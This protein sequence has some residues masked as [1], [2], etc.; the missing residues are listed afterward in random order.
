M[1]LRI[2]LYLTFVVFLIFSCS[3]DEVS[4]SPKHIYQADDIDVDN[5]YFPSDTSDVWEHI[6][7][8]DYSIDTVK[9]DEL[10]KWVKSKNSTAFLMSIKGRILTEN[11]WNGVSDSRVLPMTSIAKSFVSVMIGMAQQDGLI[12]INRL[13]SDYLGKAWS[14][15]DEDQED[16]ITLKHHLKMT[17]GLDEWPPHPESNACTKP[18]CMIYKADPDTRWAYHQGAYELLQNVLRNISDQT[19]QQYSDQILFNELGIDRAQWN[20]NNLSM[21]PR[22]LFRYGTFMLAN[23]SWKGKTLLQDDKYKSDMLNSSQDINPSYGYLW[24]LNGKESHM[25]PPKPNIFNYSIVATAPDDMY[26]AYGFLDQKLFVVPSMDLVVVRLGLAPHN[27]I[28][29]DNPFDEQ[30]WERIMEVFE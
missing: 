26:F 10:I 21:T 8:S 13:T 7:L 18:V 30:L 1:N 25:V 27:I 16:A 24:W 5:I 2:F 3:K 29:L 9:L 28:T 4:D 14:S 17:I 22:E 12:D 15:M 23:C 6:E 19:L 11:Y 20:N